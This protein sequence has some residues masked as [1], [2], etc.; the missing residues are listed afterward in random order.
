MTAE[1]LFDITEEEI[2]VQ[3]AELRL[4]R[5]KLYYGILVDMSFLLIVL[6]PILYLIYLLFLLLYHT[7][8]EIN[9]PVTDN[10]SNSSIVSPSPKGLVDYLKDFGNG[11]VFF[12]GMI[13]Y[14]SVLYSLINDIYEKWAKIQDLNI[15]LIRLIELER[16]IKADP[17]ASSITKGFFKE[18]VGLNIRYLNAYNAIIKD[19][20]QKSF[21]VSIWSGIFGFSLILFGLYM[22]FEDKSN[23]NNNLAYLSAASGIIIEF[24]SG[25]FFYLY[26]KTVRELKEYHNSL[27]DVQNIL[28]SFNIV[29]DLDGEIK[30]QMLSKMITSLLGRQESLLIERE[31]PFSDVSNS[32][33]EQQN[34]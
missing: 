17:T 15:D 18:L 25:V 23:L 1:Q 28:L 2:H 12:F 26:N 33:V 19:H 30:T 6:S 24:I 27:L 32:P 22:G 14:V 5:K 7:Q 31:S 11:L 8:I 29:Q 21:R 13:L 3:I 10:I 20:T 9:Y 4:D 16:R 34:R